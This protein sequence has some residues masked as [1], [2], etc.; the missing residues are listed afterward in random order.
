VS[1]TVQGEALE[2]EKLF[3]G[4]AKKINLLLQGYLEINEKLLKVETGEIIC[5]K[6]ERKGESSR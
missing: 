2:K 1:I 4:G 6:K 3:I 5:S